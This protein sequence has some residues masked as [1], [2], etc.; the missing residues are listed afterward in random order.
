MRTSTNFFLFS[1]S[2]SDLTLLFVGEF[3]LKVT[4]YNFRDTVPIQGDTKIER[5]S[6]GKVQNADHATSKLRKKACVVL[7]ISERALAFKVVSFCRCGENIV[8]FPVVVVWF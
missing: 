7:D 1:L 6:Q 5:G 2:V 3:L 8:F 4:F